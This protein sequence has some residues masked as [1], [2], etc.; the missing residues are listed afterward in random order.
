MMEYEPTPEE[1]IDIEGP[2]GESLFWHLKEWL[3]RDRVSVLQR[4]LDELWLHYKDVEDERLLALLGALCL[5]AALDDLLRGFAPSYDVVLEN[6]ETTF[7]IKT[8][9][10]RGLRLIPSKILNSRDLARR[11]RNDFAHNLEI[12]TFR[13][14]DT[15][16]LDK[17]EPYVRSFNAKERTWDDWPNLYR[18]LIGFALAGLTAYELQIEA[19]RNYIETDEFREHFKEYTE[20]RT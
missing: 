6:T 5:E 9:F 4:R 1:I 14:L 20:R 10:A 17:L 18:E 11:I 19:L 15:K 2:A 16:R 8:C 3:V 12:S 13:E 7:S